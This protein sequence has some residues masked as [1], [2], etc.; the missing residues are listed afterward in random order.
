MFST[1]QA[2]VNFVCCACRQTSYR[3]TVGRRAFPLA[4]AVVRVGLYGTTYFHTLHYLFTVDKATT[5]MHPF[6]LFHPGLTL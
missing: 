5:K 3:P 6:R 1:L 2:F 4:D